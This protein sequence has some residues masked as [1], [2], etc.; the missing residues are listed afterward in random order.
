MFVPVS[1]GK[2]CAH[3]ALLIQ[4]HPGCL[5]EYVRI[6]IWGSDASGMTLLRDASKC[7]YILDNFFCLRHY[8][9]EQHTFSGRIA[10]ATRL[11]RHIK[12]Y[13]LR[14]I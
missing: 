6:V 8:G 9:V 2:C 10:H 4:A 7:R 12:I 1:E 5:R 3:D 11:G 13:V 14:R